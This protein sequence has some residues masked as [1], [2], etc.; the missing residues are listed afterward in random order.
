[1]KFMNKMTGLQT[2]RLLTQLIAVGFTIFG[3][4]SLVH[5]FGLPRP[6]F[7]M[8]VIIGGMFF[9]GWGCPFG[10]IQEWLRFLGRKLFKVNLNIPNPWHR[11]LAFSRYILWGLTFF[12]VWNWRPLNSRRAFLALSAESE[13]QVAAGV[14]LIMVILLALFMDRPYCKYLCGFGAEFGLVGLGKIFTFKRSQT[15]CIS[16]KKCDQKCPM[17]LEISQIGHLRSPNCIN[18]FKCV[19]ACPVPGALTYGPALIRLEDLKDM[20]RRY[21]PPKSRTTENDLDQSAT[22]STTLEKSA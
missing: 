20:K 19:A 11:Y 18:C 8:T 4:N 3:L 16:C 22:L 21:L 2:V 5:I 12:A 9:C 14:I 1:M 15:K 7:I 17:G 13:I 10:A 6:V